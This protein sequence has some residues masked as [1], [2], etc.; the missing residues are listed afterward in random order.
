M[1]RRANEIVLCYNFYY[2]FTNFVLAEKKVS[3]EGFERGV[4]RLI[5]SVKNEIYFF[6]CE[7]QIC[8]FNQSGQHSMERMQQQTVCQAKTI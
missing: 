6:R 1:L 3:D 4:T 2:F 5:V 8:S 7:Q